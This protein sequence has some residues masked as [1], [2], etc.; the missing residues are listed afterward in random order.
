MLAVT[1]PLAGRLAD[2]VAVS[3]LVSVGLLLLS[4]SFF[5]ML[6]VGLA[7]ALALITLW[8][9]IGRI[10]LGF[11]LPSLNLGSMHGLPATR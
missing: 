2:R 5:L 10:G 4:A 1:I 11:V 3:W 6:S 9:V 8:A 7:T